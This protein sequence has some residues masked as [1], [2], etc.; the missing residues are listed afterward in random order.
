MVCGLH[1]RFANCPLQ[2]S[3]SCQSSS[4]LF[5]V[6]D[7][8]S[9]HARSACLQV[10]RICHVLLYSRLHSNNTLRDHRKTSVCQHK[11]TSHQVSDEKRHKLQNGSNKRHNKGQKRRGE[12]AG[13]KRN[14]VHRMLRSSPSIAVLQCYIQ[15]E[16]SRDMGIRS[17]CTRYRIHKLCRESYSL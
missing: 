13:G 8:I 11:W 17:H 15:H 9:D 5:V 10:F 6:F 12:N 7:V 2:P 16:V 3:Y 14:S 1:V 4:E